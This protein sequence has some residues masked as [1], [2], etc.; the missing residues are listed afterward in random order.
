[1]TGQISVITGG[2]TSAFKSGRITEEGSIEL[3][4]EYP[5]T[6]TVMT[7]DHGSET[8]STD[9]RTSDNN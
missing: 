9:I 8:T 5:E 2:D 7:S 4:F 6:D 3:K 1:M